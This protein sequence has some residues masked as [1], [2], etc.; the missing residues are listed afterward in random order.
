MV[1]ISSL[2]GS[3]V[4]HKMDQSTSKSYAFVIIWILYSNGNILWGDGNIWENHEVWFYRLRIAWDILG[5]INTIKKII[6]IVELL[7]VENQS[8]RLCLL[9]KSHDFP[10][11]NA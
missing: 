11:P 7:L 1:N 9:R 3:L 8:T 10:N 4:H 6:N 2:R 5:P